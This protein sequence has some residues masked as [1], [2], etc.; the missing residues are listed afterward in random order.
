MKKNDT[1]KIKITNNNIVL[2]Q[3]DYI[4]KIIKESEIEV[5]LDD[6]EYFLQEGAGQTLKTGLGKLTK[7][8]GTVFKIAG[9]AFKKLFKL[10]ISYP[11]DLLVAWY[12]G[13]SLRS[14]HLKHADLQRNLSKDLSAM[15]SSLEGAS[16]LNGFL[17]FAAPHAAMADFAIKNAGKADKFL[18]DRSNDFRKGWNKYT[19]ELYHALDVPKPQALNLDTGEETSSDSY[20]KKNFYSRIIEFIDLFYSNHTLKKTAIKGRKKD[21][22]KEFIQK[23]GLAEKI[24]DNLFTTNNASFERIIKNDFFAKDIDGKETLKDLI[25]YKDSLNKLFYYLRQ[26]DE[27]YLLNTLTASLRS[28]ALNN[29]NSDDVRQLF[30]G[31]KFSSSNVKN[32]SD[33]EQQNSSKKIKIK[34]NQILIKESDENFTKEFEEEAKEVLEG[35]SITML[36]TFNSIFFN[37]IY[38]MTSLNNINALSALMIVQAVNNII[39]LFEKNI[40]SNEP[41]NEN[42]FTVANIKLDTASAKIEN[43]IK[44]LEDSINNTAYEEI[45]SFV[46]DIKGSKE[47]FI[48]A[49]GDEQKNKESYIKLI[50]TLLTNCKENCL[51]VKNAEPENS[52][53]KLD[54]A[55]VNK[56]KNLENFSQLLTSVLEFNANELLASIDASLQELASSNNVVENIQKYKDSNVDLGKLNNLTSEARVKSFNSI[57]NNLSGI[58]EK[59]GAGNFVAKIKTISDKINVELQKLKEENIASEETDTTTSEETEESIES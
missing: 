41:I 34:N 31:I 25:K 47:E 30:S 39:D 40:E 44:Q 27:L 23:L 28:E 51:K 5:L 52:D 53:I 48:N 49:I 7:S 35:L 2:K 10:Y 12:F 57:K 11:K 8:I 59:S 43:L 18:E 45:E 46:E 54:A 33:K 50:N 15:E 21:I 56:I 22:D 29:K 14:V 13:K 20:E 55:K 4:T 16:T 38:I 6:S 3:E 32:K 58:V 42:I 36:A 37:D 9:T 1:K 24:L 17:A 19:D 26:N